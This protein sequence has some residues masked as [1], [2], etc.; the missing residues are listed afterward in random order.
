MDIETIVTAHNLS[1]I[2]FCS[3]WTY[4]LPTEI[5]LLVSVI[6]SVEKFHCVLAGVAA[7]ETDVT[8]GHG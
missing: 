1:P 8:V 5:F 3:R 2:L 7:V 6:L 4:L